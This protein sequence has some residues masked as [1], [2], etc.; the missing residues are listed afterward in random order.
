[1]KRESER[2]EQQSD[3]EL[4]QQQPIAREAPAPGLKLTHNGGQV[5]NTDTKLSPGQ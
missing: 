4:R 1:M 5:A 2:V 3:R